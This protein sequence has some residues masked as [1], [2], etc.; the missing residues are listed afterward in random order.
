MIKAVY[1]N[2]LP[3]NVAKAEASQEGGS[4]RVFIELRDANYLGSTYKLTYDPADDRLKG[5]YL[6]AAERR[7]F[8]VYFVRQRR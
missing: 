2:P 7:A 1:F 4:T 6:Q 5:I 3:I 8:D